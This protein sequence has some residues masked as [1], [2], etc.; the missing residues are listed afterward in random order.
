TSITNA[1]SK[2]SYTAALPAAYSAFDWSGVPTPAMLDAA[3]AELYA[4]DDIA[5]PL[6][7]GQDDGGSPLPPGDVIG[8]NSP[9]PP[10]A[11]Q[12]E[13]SSPSSSS[14]AP[15]LGQSFSLGGTVDPFGGIPTWTTPTGASL[16][17]DNNVYAP[18]NPN[19]GF[20][21][22][23]GAQWLNASET[24]PASGGS[25]SGGGGSG[26]PQIAPLTQTDPRT[27][28]LAVNDTERNRVRPVGGDLVK[29]QQAAERGMTLEEFEA[30]NE[31][32]WLQ[33]KQSM[34]GNATSINAE[35]DLN[36]NGIFGA[37]RDG[38]E[39][40]SDPLQKLVGIPTPAS[41]NPLGSIAGTTLD[42]MDKVDRAAKNWRQ[43]RVAGNGIVGSAVVVGGTALADETGVTG[44]SNAFARHEAV[45]AERE[46]SIA[47]RVI[48]ESSA[49]FS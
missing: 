32:G 42:A 37:A 25:G 1:I 23:P 29:Q 8:A 5:L 17:S 33:N 34:Q 26:A 7:A 16:L 40:I 45:N 38:A 46:Q 30:E 19:L 6:S 48:G 47:E 31:K 28:A 39:F 3:Y 35:A 44:V 18:A 49:P 11:G 36:K 15:V 12:G 21:G 10:G 20:T 27:A 43:N 14:S 41:A 22:W 2:N 13:G 9:L 4:V 24:M